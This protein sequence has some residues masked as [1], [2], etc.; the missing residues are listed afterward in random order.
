MKTVVLKF[1]GPLQSWGIKSN[2]TV[3]DTSRYPSKSAV[4]GMVGAAMGTCR[5]DVEQ[6]EKL[7]GL[8]VG[9][10]VD[11]QGSLLTDFQTARTW[12]VKYDGVLGSYKMD[13]E[14]K[15][16]NTYISD[17]H[18]LADAVFTVM[19]TH[20]DDMFVE[21][22]AFALQN[23]KYQI[24]MGRKSCP[25]PRDYFLGVYEE[26]L[27]DLMDRWP[28][29]VTEGYLKSYN[30]RKDKKG[31]VELDCYYDKELVDNYGEDLY[32]FLVKDSYKSFSIR[33][34]D[35]GYRRV[36]NR[37]VKLDLLLEEESNVGIEEGEEKSS[38]LGV[39]ETEHDLFS[40]M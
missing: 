15:S 4:V 36:I 24:F 38:L 37:R 22:V 9:V 1:A 3:R 28:W 23:P 31:Y 30:R 18:Y 8:L 27:I 2:F 25:L 17:R 39:K 6:L 13:R 26:G 7:N 33:N 34:R 35:Y 5:E 29:Q 12:D 21:E 11:K 20:E 10:R 19:L 14:G 40:N 32:S 16:Y